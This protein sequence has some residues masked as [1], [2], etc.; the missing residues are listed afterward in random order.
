MARK[1][2][3]FTVPAAEGNR[4]SGKLF[5][6]TEL[7]ASQA[8]DW[9]ARAFLALTN[10]GA[11]VPDELAAAGFQGLFIYGLK[12]FASVSFGDLKPLMDE[13]MGC[14]RI[15]PDVQKNPDFARKIIEDDIE[16]VSTRLRLKSE[17][18]DLHVGFSVAGF[19][20][21]LLS[22]ATKKPAS[23]NIPTSPNPS[24]P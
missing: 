22:E 9:A 23:S 2:K 6:L 13:L 8:E 10:S 18:I 12:S 17:I 24:A 11:D 3:H 20:S 1:T 19:L 7:S 15:V 5:L 4:D 14:A 21:Q 16:E